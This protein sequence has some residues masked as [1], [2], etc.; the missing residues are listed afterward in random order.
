MQCRQTLKKASCTQNSACCF[1]GSVSWAD[2]SYGLS[3]QT[4]PASHPCSFFVDVGSSSVSRKQEPFPRYSSTRQNLR[5]SD[6]L[7]KS[8]TAFGEGGADSQNDQQVSSTPLLSMHEERFVTVT[9]PSV[10]TGCLFPRAL[11]SFC[12]LLPGFLLLSTACEIPVELNC[13]WSPS[14][15]IVPQGVGWGGTVEEDLALSVQGGSC[16]LLSLCSHAEG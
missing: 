8:E 15:K 11:P 2:K 3:L 1:S 10:V 16:S 14:Q 12:H 9:C 13:P 5:W 7:E 6:L 4:L